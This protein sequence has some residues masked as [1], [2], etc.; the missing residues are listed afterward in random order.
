MRPESAARRAADREDVEIRLYRVIYEAIEDIEAAI[1]GMLEPTYE[2]VVLGRAE[3]RATFRVPNVG[4][5][6][7]CC[8]TEGRIV[9]QAGRASSATVVI[10]SKLA[11]LKRFKDDVRG[12]GRIRVRDRLRTVPGY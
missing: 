6:A 3:V 12:A 10:H 1:E 5:V 8:V 9:R 4:V 11:S 2:E 7:G